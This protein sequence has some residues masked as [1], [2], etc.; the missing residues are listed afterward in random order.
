MEVEGR[1]GKGYLVP[2]RAVVVGP[3]GE[4]GVS[5]A[6]LLPDTPQSDDPGPPG[7]GQG[8]VVA[9]LGRE[10]G[11]TRGDLDRGVS[12]QKLHYIFNISYLSYNIIHFLIPPTSILCL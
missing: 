10:G 7:A 6:Q 4:S 12:K 9:V 11:V 8:G 1:E 2:A 3:P 5:D